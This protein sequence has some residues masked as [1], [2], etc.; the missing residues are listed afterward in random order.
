MLA[1]VDRS[2]FPGVHP[3]EHS[4]STPA[5]LIVPGRRIS[6][7]GRVGHDPL[8]STLLYS[9]WLFSVDTDIHLLCSIG[10][11][12]TPTLYRLQST[13]EYSRTP[14]VPC[15]AVT[16]VR[17]CRMSILQESPPLRRGIHEFRDWTPDN[18]P[19]LIIQWASWPS[20]TCADYHFRTCTP[21][22]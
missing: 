2:S 9:R 20:W 3:T 22:Q 19:I 12:H 16:C 15:H 7:M 18:K 21:L 17:N 1:I 14:A 8:Y 10:L 13:L 11:V 5:V 4:Y 6:F